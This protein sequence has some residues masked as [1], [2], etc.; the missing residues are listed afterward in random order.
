MDVSTEQLN[1]AF[2]ALADPTR[3]DRRQVHLDAA[4]FDL[5]T[6]WIQRCRREAESA[7]DASMPCFGRMADDKGHKQSHTKDAS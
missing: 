1:R 2:A 7:I 5:M 6:N 4:V 3:R